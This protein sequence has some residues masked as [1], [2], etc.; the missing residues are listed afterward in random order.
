[1]MSE[2]LQALRN[3]TML[4]DGAIGSY[5]FERT[6]R[7]SEAN[8]VYEALNIHQP[9][10]IRQLHFAYLRAGSQ[11]LTTNTFAANQTHLGPLGEG[12]RTEQIN[13]AGVRLAHEAIA[14]F[15]EHTQVNKNCFVLGSLGPP[16][17]PSSTSKES[18][19]E[20]IQALVHQGVDALVLETFSRLPDVIAVVELIRQLNHALPVIVQMS[21]HQNGSEATWER[22]PI[23]YVETVAKCGVQVIGINCCA[24]WDAVSFIERARSAPAI[25]ENRAYLSATPNA[26]GLQQV[27]NRSIMRVNPEYMGKLARTLADQGARLIGGCCEVHPPHISEMRNYLSGR[28]SSGQRF[29]LNSFTAKTPTS[30][31]C[32]KANGHFSR[33]IKEGSFV[34]SVEMLP[35]R[36]T[37][38]AILQD[39]ID[40]VRELAKS[41]LADALDVTDGSRGI[42]L[43]PPGD[44]ISIIRE[45][46]E[47]TAE[48][49]DGLEF[50]CHFTARDLNTM[51]LQS[52]LLG[53]W[54]RRIHNV[55]FVSGD[56]P[57]MS[58]T[59]PRST[60]VFD[61]D[62]VDMIH[63][64]HARLN[65]GVDFGGI[66]L[67][68][69]T[70]PR[71]RFTIG[72]GFEPEA[73]DVERELD[74]LQRKVT[75]GADY[76]MTQPAFR[77]EPLAS[78]EPF[79]SRVPILIGV[80][81]LTS[82]DH[83]RR[84]SQ[85]PGVMV[86]NTI[87]QRLSTFEKPADQA[88]AGQE[89]AIEQIQW[90]C[91]EG[92]SGLYLMAPA[93]HR[94]VLETLSEGLARA[95]APCP[96][97]T[98]SGQDGLHSVN[99]SRRSA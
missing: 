56:P 43:M 11:C 1:M 25:R 81:I 41:Q 27:G 79:R 82:L 90:V 86:P 24:P 94:P 50:I 69:H 95:L 85:V 75:H 9:D 23:S 64:T 48:A 60:A 58:P 80:L 73:L 99:S 88:K 78:L 55:L 32:K 22:D 67:G 2:F 39:K 74:K 96:S 66:S 38:P 45:Q 63:H 84:V 34:V 6:G 26:G 83:A 53:Y 91:Q 47:W 97:P 15:R 93:G 98:A 65:C 89:L 12:D 4:S 92:W 8:H 7:L 13:R 33:K 71:T 35:A 16:R 10:L 72:S 62:S 40:F 76:I 31:E 3:G 44:F 87:F 14:I 59:Y 17:E 49:G 18:Y 42:A 29:D 37:C 20:Q 77:H 57:K 19:R 54:A 51:G 68:Q 52:R 5:L 28:Q 30:D 21:L 61:F 46:L 70:D 36:G